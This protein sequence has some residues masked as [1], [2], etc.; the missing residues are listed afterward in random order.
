MPCWVFSMT[1]LPVSWWHHG[2]MAHHWLT[3]LQQLLSLATSSP[4][5][6]FSTPCWTFSFSATLWDTSSQHL[7]SFPNFYMLSRSLKKA[8]DCSSSSKQLDGTTCE[9]MQRSKDNPL[10]RPL[11]S[12]RPVGLTL[13]ALGSFQK[14]LG[15]ARSPYITGVL[16]TYMYRT[17]SDYVYYVYHFYIFA[18][19]SVRPIFRPPHKRSPCCKVRK[20]RCYRSDME[21]LQYM[22][23]YRYQEAKGTDTRNILNTTYI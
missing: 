5:W 13:T 9:N 14:C 7:T 20:L 22:Q 3:K 2:I 15:A 4:F 12:Q 1:T 17:I 6:T 16:N 19:I 23:K 21:L 8:M 18:Q 11:S 10:M